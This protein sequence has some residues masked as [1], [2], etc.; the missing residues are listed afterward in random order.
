MCEAY[1][2]VDV[3]STTDEIQ[4]TFQQYIGSSYSNIGLEGQI[5][6]IGDTIGEKDAAI[7]VVDTDTS[8]DIRLI[9]SAVS[10][11]GTPTDEGGFIQIWKELS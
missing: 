8:A 6:V 10:S 4:F 1:P 3:A 5:Q 9:V 7:C 11:S 2:Y